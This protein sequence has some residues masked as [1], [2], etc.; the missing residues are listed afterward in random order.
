MPLSGAQWV[1]QFPT[2]SGLDDL[3]EPFRA[4]AKRYISAIR[5]AHATLTISDTL[6]PPQRVCPMH[7]SFAI[8]REG[9]DPASVPS[10]AGVDVQWVHA[11]SAGKA[12]LAASKKAAEQMVIGYGIVFKPVLGSRHTEVKA[13]HGCQLAE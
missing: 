10:M 12:D 2:S 7:F 13:R 9:L 4:N 3:T 6:R 11:D 5:A 1:P 8:E